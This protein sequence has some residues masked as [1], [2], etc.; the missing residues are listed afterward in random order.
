MNGSAD[1]EAAAREFLSTLGVGDICSGTVSDFTRRHEVSVI[2]DGFPARA[3]G[4]IFSSDRSWGRSSAVAP[5]EAGQRITAEVISIDL[6]ACRARLAMTATENPELW[7][8]LKGRRQGETLTGTIASIERFGVFVALDEAPDHPIFPGVGFISYAELSW[9]HFDTATDVVQVGQHVACEFLQFDTW[10]GEARLSLKAMQPDPLMAFAEAT[11]VG[12]GLRGRV[13]R[14]VPF[15][16]FVEVAHGI[17]GL[18]H[19]RED[20]DGAPPHSPDGPVQ[21]GDEVEVIVSDIDRPRRRVALSWP[22]AAAGPP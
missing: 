4:R 1:D 19:Q 15:G 10:N 13:T 22:Q 11:A 20:P 7:A 9:A 17:E 3:L 5:P 21:V 6:E 2:L 18:L 16:I 8:F 12:Q 14:L